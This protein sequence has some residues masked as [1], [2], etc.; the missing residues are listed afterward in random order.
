MIEK[1][2]HAQNPVNVAILNYVAEL[3]QASYQA[4]F[5]KFGN[6]SDSLVKAHARFSKKMEYL[7]FTQQLCSTGRGHDRV[8]SIGP[9]AGKAGR[10][11]G[12]ADRSQP[13]S[14]AGQYAAH[15]ARVRSKAAAAAQVAPAAALDTPPERTPPNTYDVM[16][17]PV[18]VPPRTSAA[19]RPGSLDYR[20]HAS[21]GVR[22]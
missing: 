10:S 3:D 14:P 1:T 18:F 13:R 19:L 5:D 2:H 9:E 21:H 4:L 12:Y 6:L 7:C 11:R 17:A 8:F 16:R 20:D 22:C 15:V